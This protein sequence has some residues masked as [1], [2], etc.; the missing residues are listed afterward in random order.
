MTCH[1]T[2]G[3]PLFIVIWRV[4]IIELDQLLREPCRGRF[5]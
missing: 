1:I 2:L 5:Q 3:Q 4:Q